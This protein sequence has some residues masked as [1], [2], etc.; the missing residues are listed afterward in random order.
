MKRIFLTCLLLCSSFAF[1]P[2]VYA[3]IVGG[4]PIQGDP[5]VGRGIDVSVDYILLARKYRNEGR[6]ELAR[7]SYAQALSVCNNS[8]NLEVIRR[9]L[10]GIELLIRTMR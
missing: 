6:Y 5:T 10:A 8:A 2:P 4:T 1:I 3:E 9:E 7:Q